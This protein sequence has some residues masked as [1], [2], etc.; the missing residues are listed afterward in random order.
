[1]CGIAVIVSPAI[2]V[3]IGRIL[4]SAVNMHSLF[5]SYMTGNAAEQSTTP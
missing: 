4:A 5:H 2:G 3:P 1:V